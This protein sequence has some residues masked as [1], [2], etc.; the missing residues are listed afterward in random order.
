VSLWEEYKVEDVSEAVSEHQ[1]HIAC[2]HVRIPR[3]LYQVSY[4]VQYRVVDEAK[5]EGKGVEKL[6]HVCV[7]EDIAKAFI[8][9]LHRETKNAAVYQGLN[10]AGE[11]HGLSHNGENI[12]L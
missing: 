8:V 11:G 4:C 5:V 3:L 1:I 7:A 12:Q 10:L 2:L 9:D 6:P